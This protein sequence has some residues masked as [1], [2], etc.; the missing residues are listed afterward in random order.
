M[1]VV[2]DLKIAVMKLGVAQPVSETVERFI[3]TVQIPG[4]IACIC[5]F[6][7]FGTSCLIVVIVNRYLADGIWKAD[8]EP[9]GR[10]I[11]AGYKLCKGIAGF[12]SGEPCLEYRVAVGLN[13]GDF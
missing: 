2:S 8:R 10:V 6:L 11:C 5:T 7:P 3:R 13:R 4:Y 12:C 9:S 1:A